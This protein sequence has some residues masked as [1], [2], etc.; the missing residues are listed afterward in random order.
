MDG[1]L[2]RTTFLSLRLRTRMFLL[3]ASACIALVTV[4]VLGALLL[5]TVRINGAQYMSIRN[6]KDALEKIALLKSDIYQLNSEVLNFIAVRGQT[7]GQ[8]LLAK[9]KDH[10]DDIDFKYS[11]V[12][13]LISSKEKRE[14]I[15][16]AEA[17][18]NDYRQTLLE[19]IIPA[20]QRGDLGRAQAL[21]QGTQR[22]RFSSFS[23][24]IA[25]MVDSLR[26]DVYK[27][28]QDVAQTIRTK[29]VLTVGV[30]LLLIGLIGLFAFI[31]SESVTN[32]IKRC[33]SFARKVAD[34]DL[35]SPLS[36]PHCGELGDLAVAMN[37]MAG[38]LRSLA[39]RLTGSTGELTSIDRNIEQAARQVVGATRL[40]EEVVQEA[41]RT[42]SLMNQSVDGINRGV[43]QL[44]GSASG[45]AISIMQITASIEEVAQNSDKLGLSVD[46]VSASILQMANSISEVSNTISN[47]VDA[48]TSTASAITEMDATIR[49]VERN[50]MDTALIT[51]TVKSDAAHGLSAVQET[52]SGMQEIRRASQDTAELVT[53]LSQRAQDIG[54][55]LSV[56][57]DVAEQTNLLALNAAIIAA[58]AGEHGKG[59]AV[60]ADEIKEL[61]ERTSASTREISQM[62]SGIQ[63]ETD[64]AVQAINRAAQ[65]VHD[66]EQV[67]ERAGT[68]LDKIVTSVQQTSLQV[69][70]ITRATLEQAKGSRRIKTAMEQVEEIVVLMAHNLKEHSRGSA[71][72]THEVERIRSLTAGVRSSTRAQSEMS[73]LIA[74]ATEDITAMIERIRLECQAQTGHSQSVNKMVGSIRQS[75][76]ASTQAAK[77]LQGAV[78]GLSQQIEQL[79]KDVS[80]LTI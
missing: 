29:T 43:E 76:D 5:D 80:G 72:I 41:T 71:L 62:I 26:R 70:A 6:S 45:T 37:T 77:V 46:E 56:I 47:L 14:A 35:T 60:V 51:E 39:V 15:I 42:A 12:Q 66:G 21:L 58:Q 33:V 54:T 73:S 22:Q 1:S 20:V 3:S 40:Q 16:K 19:E 61:A 23:S 48:S 11:D 75:S 8:A 7:E 4:I 17:I 79:E 68:A 74:E 50:A 67:S 36:I 57:D 27:T 25:F 32:P 31:I 24:T 30:T 64:R 44:S 38:N 65:V 59:F 53:N 34:G 52:I 13:R 28:E 69:D 18:W 78:T 55:I 2:M 49:Q 63:A 10:S 9:I